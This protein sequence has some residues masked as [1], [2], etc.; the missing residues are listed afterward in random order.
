VTSY[1]VISLVSGLLF[2]VLDGFIHANPLAVRL[3]QVYRPITRDSVNFILGIGIDILYGF[4][5]AGV[6]LVLSPSLPGA[7]G[8]LRGISFGVLVWIF[9]V[10]MDV[11]S[12]WVMYKIPAKTLVYTLLT[13]L[14]EMVVLGLL[15]GAGFDPALKL[16]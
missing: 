4:L 13:G 14:A 5:L 15:Y 3:Y 8:L 7:N 9:R 11:L 10:V 12:Q 6:F 16:F 1:I 2:G